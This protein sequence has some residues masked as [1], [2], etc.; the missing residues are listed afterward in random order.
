[1][2][3]IFTNAEKE[4]DNGCIIDVGFPSEQNINASETERTNTRL[5][6][7]Y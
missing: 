1:L 2:F 5:G 6:K 3:E 7:E 4:K